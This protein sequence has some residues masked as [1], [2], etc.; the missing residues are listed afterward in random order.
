[1]GWNADVALSEMITEELI[2]RGL[3]LPSRDGVSVPLHPAVRTTFLVLLSQL[4]RDAGRRAGLSLYPAT[5]SYGAIEDLIS[6]MSLQS[7][8]S[9]GH[10][11]TLD[12]ETVGLDLATVPLED[13]LEF[14]EH[15]GQA[16]R[17]YARNVRQQVTELGLLEPVEREARLL[18]RREELADLS[19][20]LRRTARQWWRRP[21]G[22]FALGAAGAAWLAMGPL[23]DPIGGAL[24]LAGTGLAAASAAGQEPATAYS[25]ILDARRTLGSR[26]ADGGWRMPW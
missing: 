22:S 25:Y 6:V 17:A 14:R 2:A 13:I 19:N 21:L 7:S 4:A 26:S 20:D 9:A 5:A 12:Q 11:V 16:Y 3:A 1:M 8:P 15:H 10:V 18:D 23:H 24:A